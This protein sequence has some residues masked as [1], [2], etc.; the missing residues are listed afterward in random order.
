MLAVLV[1]FHVATGAVAV[2]AGAVAATVRKGKTT[3][4][5]AGRL[6]VLLMSAS[7]LLGAVLGLIRIDQFFITFFAGLLGTYL[8][9]SGWLAASRH[10]S[11]RGVVLWGLG[12]INAANCAAL[13]LIGLHALSGIDGQ[14]YGFAG[15]DYLFLAAMSGIAVLLDGS[16]IFRKGLSAKHKTARHLWRMLLGFFIAAGSAFTGPGAKVFPEPVQQSGILSV[17]ELLIMLLMLFYLVRTIFL[18]S[19]ARSNKHAIR[20]S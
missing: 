7:S 18:S 15:E 17:P 5:S 9:L 6:F 12:F 8:V 4:I 3:H 11:D 2:L 19:E 1:F 14:L 13:I 20:P 10:G 16:L